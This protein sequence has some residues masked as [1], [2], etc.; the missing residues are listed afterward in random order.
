MREL[1]ARVQL[2]TYDAS[3]IECEAHFVDMLTPLP[4]GRTLVDL[5]KLSDVEPAVTP[6]EPRAQADPG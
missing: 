5:R 3:R 2:A 4:D 1:I 6:S